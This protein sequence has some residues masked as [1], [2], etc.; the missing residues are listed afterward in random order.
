MTQ[1]DL[2]ILGRILGTVGMS[3]YIL[4]S[5]RFRRRNYT[6]HLEEELKKARQRELYLAGMIDKYDVEID[7]FDLIALRNL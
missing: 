7:E 6:Q 2:I 4:F 5:G 1:R 3:S